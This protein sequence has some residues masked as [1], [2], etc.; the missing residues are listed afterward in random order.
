MLLITISLFWIFQETIP[1]VV[2]HFI[3]L[4]FL[5][6]LRLKLILTAFWKPIYALTFGLIGRQNNIA[7]QVLWL[8]RGAWWSDENLLWRPNPGG[9][10]ISGPDVLSACLLLGSPRTPV[11]YTSLSPLCVSAAGSA[12]CQPS[13][14]VLWALAGWGQNSQGQNYFY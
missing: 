11:P 12:T 7:T 6:L 3:Y 8:C 5:L 4:S 2:C 13:W 10:K 9:E 1:E 14:V